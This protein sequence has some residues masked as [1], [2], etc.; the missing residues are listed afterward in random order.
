MN[1]SNISDLSSTQTAAGLQNSA[2]QGNA[3]SSGGWKYITVQEGDVVYTYIVIGKNM[4]ILVGKT[5]SD[6]KDGDKQKQAAKDNKSTPGNTQSPLAAAGTD[7]KKPDFLN[8]LRMFALTGSYQKKCRETLQALEQQIGNEGP[9]KSPSTT[10]A[11]SKS[12]KS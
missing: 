4:K 7:M 1:L 8:D 9:E 6:D 11:S 2:S 10:A 5:D 12:R 3:D